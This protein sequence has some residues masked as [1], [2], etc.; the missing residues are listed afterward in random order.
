MQLAPHA[1]VFL[2]RPYSAGPHASE[3][4]V[5]RLHGACEHEPDGLKRGDAADLDLAAL[6]AHRGLA[7]VPGDQVHPLDLRDRDTERLGDRRLDQPLAQADAHLARDDLDEKPRLLG[8]EALKKCF[9]RFCLRVAARGADRLQRFFD[10]LHADRLRG[11]ACV[12]GLAGP[13]AQ[14]RVLAKQRAKLLLVAAGDRGDDLAQRRPAQPQRTA[15]R[16]RKGP[17]T[18]VDGGTPQVILAEG[19]EIGAED[20]RLLERRRRRSH[21]RTCTREFTQGDLS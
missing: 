8:I 16:R 11:R 20:P 7:N 13:V 4:F 9:E 19:A 21:G 12:Q 6:Q 5:R 15:L 2:L 14:V 3:S 1:V 10:V 17:A 18:H